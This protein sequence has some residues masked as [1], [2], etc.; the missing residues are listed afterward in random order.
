[1]NFFILGNDQRQLALTKYLDGIKISDSEKLKTLNKSYIVL[2]TPVSKDGKFISESKIPVDELSFIPPGNIVFGG[3][4]PTKF[5]NFFDK[6]KIKWVD[7]TEVETLSIKNAIST[8]E[9]AI[10]IILSN[11]DTT[12]NTSVC[13]V[14]GYGRIGK[15]TGKL[16]KSF[17]ATVYASSRKPEERI[18]IEYNGLIPISTYDI[19]LFI[20]KADII[21]NTVPFM[22]FP[23]KSLQLMKKDALLLDLASKPGGVDFEY[24]KKHNLNIIHALSLPSK[25]SPETS[26]KDMAD[27]IKEII[28]EGV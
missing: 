15:V 7:L 6:K 1:M 26:G 11:L 9:G 19:N 14:A 17:G 8:A 18:W 27:T 22:V 16:L 4:I 13:L 12:I 10:S 28:K 23:S 24:G 25:C 3:K 2:P 5:R 20:E 21:V